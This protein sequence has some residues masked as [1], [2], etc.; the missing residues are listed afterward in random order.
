MATLS[1]VES[2]PP[3]EETRPDLTWFDH[4]WRY[5]ACAV[6]SGALWLPVAGVEWN[7]HQ[8][9][10]WAE[11]LAGTAGFVLV[12]FRRRAPLL[13]ALVIA[14]LST[15]SG[16]AAGPATLAAVSLATL[17]QPVPIV[18]V[19]ATNFVC[20]T[21]WTQVAPFDTDGITPLTLLITFA[22]NAGMMGWGMYLGS[23]RELVWTLR[24]R[25]ERAEQ[26]RDARVRQARVTERSRIAREM[27]DVLAHRITQ[28]SMQAG[29]LAFR[30]DLDATHLRGGLTEI[31]GQANAALHELRGVLG[32]LREDGSGEPQAAPQPTYDDIAR[33]VA[34]AQRSGMNVQLTDSLRHGGEVPDAVARTAYRIIQEGLT[35]A[36]KHAPGALVTVRLSG[37]PESGLDV[38]VRNPLGFATTT[39]GAGLGLV[40]LRERAELAGGRL[41]HWRDGSAF[42][43]HGW[44]PWPA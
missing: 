15:V 38:F 39:P 17:R 6:F 16:I 8:P 35:N 29:A 31:Q 44:I 2:R 34:D 7:E 12:G 24:H 14:V 23:R 27:H 40:G 32:V 5:V 21:A 25:A 13:I 1:P 20:G 30:D 19:G 26:E 42:V 11:V 33:L 36:R 10:F 41:T 3:P 4:A 43:L 28:V 22:V 37:D 18:T 9:L